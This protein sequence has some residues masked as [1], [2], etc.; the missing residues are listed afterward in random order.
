[1]PDLFRA[2]AATTV[3]EP[4]IVAFPREQALAAFT[5]EATVTVRNLTDA[6]QSITP[7]ATLEG[8]KAT[9]SPTTLELPANGSA[10]LTV[11]AEATGT[12]RPPRYLT[13]TLKLGESTALLGLPVGPPPPVEL[14]DLSVVEQ[15]GKAS[16]VR[17]TAGALAHRGDAVEVQPLGDLTL[18]IID[19][20]G[21][22]ARELTPPGGARDLLPGQYAYTLTKQAKADL[23]KGPYRFRATAHGPVEAPPTVRTSEEFELR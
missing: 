3:A 22:V 2:K 8:T 10:E 16:G 18:E 5:A 14:S 12:E 21:S 9:V 7:T 6:E 1:V 13:G 19:A 11:S 23:G 20:H 15:G 17:F 4:A